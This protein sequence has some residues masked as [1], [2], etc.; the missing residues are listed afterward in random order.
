MKQVKAAAVLPERLI[1]EIQQYVQ[2]ETIYIPRAKKEH[3]RWGSES[4]ARKY[5]DERNAQ[6]KQEYKNGT[7]LSILA[8]E[9]H[10]S[11]ETIKKIVYSKV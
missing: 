4:G 6:I 11:I 7:A 8:E 10:L 3:K 5:L 2:G 1:A 9:Y